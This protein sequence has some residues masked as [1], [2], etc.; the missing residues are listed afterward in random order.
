MKTFVEEQILAGSDGNA[1][2]YIRQLL[3]EAQERKA[4]ARLEQLLIEGI[5]SGPGKPITAALLSDLRTDVGA[6]IAAHKKSH[7]QK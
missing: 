3:R 7:S 5:N 1:S 6:R 2:E 4:N